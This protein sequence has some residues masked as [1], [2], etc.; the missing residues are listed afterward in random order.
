MPD[1][2]PTLLSRFTWPIVCRKRRFWLRKSACISAATESTAAVPRYVL[3]AEFILQKWR[4]ADGGCGD[5][6]VVFYR[7]FFLSCC[8]LQRQ[9]H[10]PS[11]LFPAVK[12]GWQ[13][14]KYQGMGKWHAVQPRILVN[15]AMIHVSISKISYLCISCN[16]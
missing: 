15:M 3:L 1:V 2:T 13:L 16:L 11:L 9:K 10:D 8:V 5:R 6:S 7:S 12:H 14:T 4:G